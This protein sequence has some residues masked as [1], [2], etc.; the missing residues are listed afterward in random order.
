M[1]ELDRFYRDNKEN[2]GLLIITVWDTAEDVRAVL[3]EGSELPVLIDST[4]EIPM[5]YGV[6]GVPTAFFIDSEGGMG[7]V[8]A[9]GMTAAEMA[10]AVAAL[11]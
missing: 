6:E 5:D 8:R 10:A 7:E 3:G 1:P 4:G 2:T 9:G 11:Q